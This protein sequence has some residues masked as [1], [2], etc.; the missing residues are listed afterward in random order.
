MGVLLKPN[1]PEFD[2]GVSDLTLLH[3]DV[4]LGFLAS[5]VDEHPQ[6]QAFLN[7]VKGIHLLQIA[8]K[9]EI[10]VCWAFYSEASAME[11]AWA[12]RAFDAGFGVF[13]AY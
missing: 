9:A 6:K 3:I 12:R 13:L 10:L 11:S 4:E 1:T 2:K 5:S 8:D 7:R